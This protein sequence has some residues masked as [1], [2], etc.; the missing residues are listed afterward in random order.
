MYL[1]ITLMPV[2]SPDEQDLLD[3]V[4][5]YSGEHIEQG[6][7][8]GI[9]YT[10]QVVEEGGG[11]EWPEQNTN[12]EGQSPTAPQFLENSYLEGRKFTISSGIIE[13]KCVVIGPDY[14]S[15][16]RVCNDILGSIEST[17]S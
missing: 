9:L 3:N 4:F 2:D 6:E 1:D 17:Q 10:G 16:V 8:T 15:Y 13:A 5:P 11:Q 14:E 12:E 7:L